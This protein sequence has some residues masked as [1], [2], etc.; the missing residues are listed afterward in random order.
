MFKTN[1]ITKYFELARGRVV[2]AK[3]VGMAVAACRR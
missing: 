3:A 2:A 1:I